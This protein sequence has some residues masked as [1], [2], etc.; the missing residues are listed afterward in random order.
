MWNGARI[1]VREGRPFSWTQPVWKASI[2]KR[3]SSARR[4]GGLHI[5]QHA[6][7]SRQTERITVEKSI[8][9]FAKWIISVLGRRIQSLGL[10]S[11][12]NQQG[13][14]CGVGNFAEVLH[15]IRLLYRF[16]LCFCSYCVRALYSGVTTQCKWISVWTLALS[17]QVDADVSSS[18]DESTQI[19]VSA[20]VCE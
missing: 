9:V 1:R 16:F 6:A 11:A 14:G 7:N 12:D 13:W 2:R 15:P 3:S 18:A 4:T 10:E 8:D 19:G 20:L 5:V 17:H